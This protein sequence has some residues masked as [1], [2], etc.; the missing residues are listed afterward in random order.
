ML[1]LLRLGW[2]LAVLFLAAV[3]RGLAQ[4]TQMK[5]EKGPGELPGKQWFVAYCAQCHGED[6]KGHGR[7][8]KPNEPA[9]DLTT[10]AQRNKGKFPTDYVKKVLI[11]GVSVPAH[12]SADMPVWGR[13]FADLNAR[14][15]IEYL[16][17][18]Q[19]K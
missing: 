3:P 13:V 8:S 10:L 16:E 1:R 9:P 12:G 17:S 6:A 18:I 11:H 15:L 14:E 7:Y 2:F 5:N 19:A 4:Q